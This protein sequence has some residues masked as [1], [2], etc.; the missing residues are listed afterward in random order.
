MYKPVFDITP[1]LLR[2]IAE[3]T[4]LK[5]WIQGSVINV[6]WLSTLQKETLLRLTHSSTAIEGNPL[7]LNQVQSVV[8]GKQV[9]ASSQATLEVSNQYEALQWVFKQKTTDK[10][11]EADLLNLHRLITQNV[12][13]ADQIGRYKT[14][15]NRVVDGNGRTVYSPPPPEKSQP[16]TLDLLEWINGPESKILHPVM[17]SS[18][19]HFQL[20]SIHP[21]SDGNGRISR[22]LAI[23][24]LYIRGFDTDH[25]CALD[26]YFL[27]DRQLYYDKL[28]QARDLDNDLS[29]WLEYV[30]QGVVGTLSQTKERIL[31][32]QVTHHGPKINLSSRQEEVLRLLRDRG[33]LKSPDFEKSLNLT[34]A[35]LAQILKP[36]ID[37]GLIIREGQTRSTT[38]RLK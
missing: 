20:V 31:S 9:S 4:E 16:L 38:Y 24:L 22:A 5:S 14:K 35:R 18:I 11:R 23:W 13:F 30:A 32:L 17:V 10:I 12:L 36:L 21:F 19:A 6:P 34:R 15:P 26:E 28:T 27:N 37:T 33:R 25:I 29:S 8:E 2:L 7:S 1:E 3:A